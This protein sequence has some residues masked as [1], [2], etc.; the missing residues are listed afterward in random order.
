MAIH[1]PA[2]P[3]GVVSP[4]I[5]HHDVAWFVAS[6]AIVLAIA[7]LL[8]IPGVMPRFTTPMSEQQRSLIEYR[9]YE[10]L[11]RAASEAYPE[12]KALVEFRA[13]ERAGR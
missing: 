1:I 13:A 9:A 11:D 2:H 4:Q 7:A 12:W 8:A 10:R 5:H 6:V 3:S